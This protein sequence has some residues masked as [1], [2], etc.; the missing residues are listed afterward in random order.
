[1]QTQNYVYY[2]HFWVLKESEFA[3][4]K[5]ATF[6]S[7]VF[8]HCLNFPESNTLSKLLS[9]NKGGGFNTNICLN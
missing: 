4:K 1:M 3:C 8:K 7:Y 9:L 2:M 6:L 5:S